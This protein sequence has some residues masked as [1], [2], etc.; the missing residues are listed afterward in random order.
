VIKTRTSVPETCVE[1]AEL[2]DEV[3]A[4]LNRN[5]RDNRLTE[6][7]RDYTINSQACRRQ[8]SP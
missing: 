6:M 7:L 4:R 3:I 5:I 8:A 1:T 2:A